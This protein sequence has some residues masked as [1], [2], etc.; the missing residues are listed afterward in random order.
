MENVINLGQIDNQ[1]PLELAS[2]GIMR[3]TELLNKNMATAAQDYLKASTEAQNQEQGITETMKALSG[4][5]AFTQELQK[6]AGVP[7]TQA[8]LR[9]IQTS[10][11]LLGSKLA[12]TTLNQELQAIGT[13][14]EGSFLDSRIARAN[15]ETA[16]QQLQLAS[17]GALLQGNLE[18]AQA[19]ID[20]AV[21]AKYE[22]MKAELDIKKYNLDRLDKRVL[23]PAQQAKLK[24]QER[25]IDTQLKEVAQQEELVGMLNKNQAP[26]SIIDKALKANSL[27]ELYE[28]PGIQSYFMSPA[29]KLDMQLK[30]LQIKKIRNEMTG[31]ET[32]ITPKVLPNGKLDVVSEVQQ[33]ISSAGKDVPSSGAVIGVLDSLQKLALA[34]TEGRFI[35]AAP[36]RTG[37][38]TGDARAERITNQSAINAI[39]LKVQQWA[40]GASLTKEQEKQV[41]RLTPDK[42]DTDFKIKEKVNSLTEFMQGQV[43]S[44][45]ATKGIAYEPTKV[46]YFAENKPASS[47]Q[48]DESGNITVPGVDEDNASF[49]NKQ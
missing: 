40:S 21:K 41:K 18:T 12:A 39:N 36:I 28:I 7:E 46:D 38:R 19:F 31:Q 44:E 49:F 10:S 15:R 26:K 5:E 3:G 16:I 37:L 47:L 30:G 6:Q 43:R 42:N 20:Q 9:E 34:N 14:E 29:D 4:Q 17:Q 1:K 8:K 45:L 33:V 11:N 35:G 25:V 13:A 2:G 32:T 48:V 27:K 24:A 23:E 22:P